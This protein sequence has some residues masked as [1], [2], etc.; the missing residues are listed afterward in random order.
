M[1]SMDYWRLNDELSVLDAAL[2]I[3]GCDPSGESSYAEGWAIEQRPEG[4]E[5]AKRALMT[6]ING[7]RLRASI[8]YSAREY[9]WAER[10]NDIEASEAEFMTISGSSLEDDERLSKQGDFVYQIFPDWK[11]TTV[12]VDDLRTWLA[13]RGLRPTFF[14]PEGRSETADYLNPHHP[15]Y[16]PKLAAAVRAWQAVDDPKGVHPRQALEKWLREHSV[17]FGLTKEDGKLSEK[18]IGECSTVANWRPGG[19]AP[20]TPTRN[21]PTP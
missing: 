5:A 21:T 8:R 15:R 17:E 18:G 4:Y 3:V 12:K 20:K 11:L 9:G 7:K 16:A 19:G 10:L 6:A 2:L 1:D 13:Q 14:F